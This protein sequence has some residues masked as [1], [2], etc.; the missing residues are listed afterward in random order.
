[1]VTLGAGGAIVAVLGLAVQRCTAACRWSFALA[2]MV[3]LLTAMYARQR[4]DAEKSGLYKR[5]TAYRPSG[6]RR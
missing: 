2:D 5:A 4:T 1:M 6:L 3:A